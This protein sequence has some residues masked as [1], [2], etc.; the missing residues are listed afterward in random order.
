MH[1]KFNYYDLLSMLVPGTL[2]VGSVPFLFPSITSPASHVG[3]PDAFVV[4]LLTAVAVFLGQAVQAVA[5]LV[6]PVLYWTWRGR[7]SDRALENGI[8]RYLPADAA[9]RIRRKLQQWV[10][11][12][13]TNHALFLF[14]M[15]Q[16]D[17]A[18]VG[19]A[20]RFN[21]LYAYHRGL[22]VLL[23]ILMVMLS[24]SAKWGRA[25]AWDWGTQLASFA[26]LA[27]LVL[28]M[29][30]RARQRANYYVREVLHIAERL[31]EEWKG[32]EHG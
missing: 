23:V 18:D 31:Y 27:L 7:P 30:H 1:D 2:L 10:G 26:A 3:I 11:S 32:A 22:V 6:E 24:L 20:R 12:D 13:A 29:W 19:R 9:K 25:A 17:G 14:A 8:P 21:S 16:A 15:Q 28:L 4:V 5:S